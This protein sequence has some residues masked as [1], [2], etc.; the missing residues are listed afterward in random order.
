M[1]ITKQKHCILFWHVDVILN[2]NFTYCKY[3]IRK[4]DSKRV[5]IEAK[6]NNRNLN[7]LKW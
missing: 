3:K 1:G 5:N 6:K 2:S 4:Y 7:W